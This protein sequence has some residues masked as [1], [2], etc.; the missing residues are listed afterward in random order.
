M[1]LAALAGVALAQATVADER[2]PQVTVTGVEGALRDNVIAYLRLDDERCDAPTWRVRRLYRE[3]EREVRRALEAFGYY[4]ARVARKF[5]RDAECWSVGVD[6]ELGEPVLLRKVDVRV[7][8]AG[9]GMPEFDKLVVA[10]PFVAGQVLNHGD[11]E[12]YKRRF[13]SLADRRGFFDGRFVI[14]RVDVY[15]DEYAADVIVAYD[16]GVRYAFGEV[17]FE[18]DVIRPKLAQAYVDFEPGQPYDARRI[19]KLYEAL[20]GTGYFYGVD[21]RTT[22][23]GAPDYDVPIVIRMD[24]AK[25]RSY[26]GGIGFGTDTGIKIRAGFL[27]R[28]LNKRGHQFEINGNWSEVLADAGTSYRFPLN[29]PRKNWMQ[30]DAGYKREDSGSIYSQTWKVGAKMFRRQTDNW[31]LTYFVD[32]GFEKW[33]VGIDEGRSRLLVPGISWEHSMDSGP[34]RPLAGV[35][36]SLALSGASETLLSE[37]DFLQVRGLGKFVH[38]L[39]PGARGLGRAELGYTFKNDVDDLPASVRFFAGGDVSVRGYDYKSLGPTDALGLVIGGTHLAVFSYELDQRVRENWSV[40]AFVDAG[41]AFNDF[42]D[43]GLEAGIGI[44]V[45][46]FS[47]LGPIRVDFAIPLADDAPDDWRIHISLGPDL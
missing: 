28:R 9:A 35:K 33:R 46:W 19:T 11:Y 22:P 43:M 30:L 42:G 37:T 16:T 18:Q 20:L 47:L 36:A 24:A 38:P 21:I 13:T 39:W 26:T 23:R 6:I 3:A 5:E 10:A 8:G 1:A 15:P 32:L 2:Q 41:N 29:D 44:G 4:S 12:A 17:V 14:S 27:H 34:P 45:R 7:I 25:H 40:A 31:L